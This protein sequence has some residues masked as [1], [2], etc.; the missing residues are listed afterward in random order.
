MALTFRGLKPDSL[1]DKK[2]LIGDRTTKASSPPR[3]T[4]TMRFPFS[5]SNSGT[6]STE[7]TPSPHIQN[8]Q[9]SSLNLKVG[10]SQHGANSTEV[11]PAYKK[12]H[13]HKVVAINV[14][15]NVFAGIDDQGKANLFFG[16]PLKMP[17]S[18][19]KSLGDSKSDQKNRRWHPVT[20]G[21]L[22]EEFTDF[23]WVLVRSPDHA[24]GIPLS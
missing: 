6:G 17:D 18:A 21:V 2:V 10:N 8:R 1:S 20:K 11:P 19:V 7:T 16:S 23:A 9:S 5:G 12:D 14:V 4:S 15:T 24:L 22:K 13:R 3:R